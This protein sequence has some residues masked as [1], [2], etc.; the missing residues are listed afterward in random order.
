MDITHPLKQNRR[1]DVLRMKVKNHPTLDTIVFVFESYSLFSQETTDSK[2][3]IFQ[4]EDKDY[5]K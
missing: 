3:K 4:I 2:K 1:I 5:D